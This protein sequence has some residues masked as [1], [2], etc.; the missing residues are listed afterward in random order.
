MQ[1]CP[2]DGTRLY[3]VDDD[4]PLVGGVIDGR[5]RIDYTLGVGGMGTV[6]GGVQLSVNRDVAVKV[7]R[8][9]LATREVALERFFREAKTIS[10]LTHPNIVKLIDFGQDRER[11][12]LYLVME[13]V[14]GNNLAELIREGRLRASMALEVVYQVCGALTEPHA[15]GVIHRDL[16]PDNLLLVPVSDGTAQVKVLDFGIARFMESNTQLTGTGMIC[17]TPA[18]MAPEQAQNEKLD[19]RTDLYALG[20][21][22]YEMLS[23]WPPFSGTSSLQIMLKHIQESPP[24]LRE[25]LPPATLPESLENLVYD[26]MSKQRRG[27]PRTAREVRMRVDEIRKELGLDPVRLHADVERDAAFDDFVLPKLP[28]PDREKSGPT[29]I[30]R[31]E[32]D[33]EE[34]V[35]T[36]MDHDSEPST[37]TDTSAETNVWDKGRP[38]S[39]QLGVTGP[40]TPDGKKRV[41]EDAKRVKVSTKEGGQQAW[42]PGDQNAVRG[43]KNTKDGVDAFGATVDAPS[44]E[45]AAAGRRRRT[46]VEADSSEPMLV[47]APETGDEIPSAA[48]SGSPDRTITHDERPE[49]RTASTPSNLPLAIVAVL[50]GVGAIAAAYYVVEKVESISASNSAVTQVEETTEEVAPKRELTDPTGDDPTELAEFVDARHIAQEELHAGIAH[51][52]DAVDGGEERGT[53]KTVATQKKAAGDPRTA[54]AAP[55]TAEPPDVSAAEAPK[56][57]PTAEPR[58]ESAAEAPKKPPTTD[59]PGTRDPDNVIESLNLRDE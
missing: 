21:I 47:T 55:V 2:N 54:A 48:R 42:T 8:T 56:K 16:K 6:Y 32:T 28:R 10:N 22:M 57:P 58:S 19:A 23:G 45:Q 14:R 17:G 36:G 25:L 7:L 5:F 31:R 59:T 20:V 27:R 39:V 46:M 11:G 44:A 41:L 15:A 49:V 26:L 51:A 52:V 24:P 1:V 4:D 43:I 50:A 53:S 38:E 30:L 13:L 37:G 40:L 33:L 35:L 9:E 34:A 3:R 12:L 29:Q 18:Y